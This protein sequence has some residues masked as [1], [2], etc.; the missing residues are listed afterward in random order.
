ML[1]KNYIRIYLI[2]VA[3][4]AVIFIIFLTLH[5]AGAENGGTAQLDQDLIHSKVELE[6]WQSEV[7]RGNLSFADY[8][9]AFS[10]DLG[11][12]KSNFENDAALT[13]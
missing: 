8:R 4:L 11:T 9:T 13:Y 3:T 5:H 10:T 7:A 6:G 2:S 1:Q 12:M